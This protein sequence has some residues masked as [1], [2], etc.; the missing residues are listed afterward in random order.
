[1][2][3]KKLYKAIDTFDK[4]GKSNSIQTKDSKNAPTPSGELYSAMKSEVDRNVAKAKMQGI[5]HV[6]MRKASKQEADAM[7]SVNSKHGGVHRIEAYKSDGVVEFNKTKHD[8]KTPAGLESYRKAIT[9]GANAMDPTQA[10]KFVEFLGDKNIEGKF[11]DE[12]AQL[13][14]TLHQ[15]GKGKINANRLVISGHGMPGGTIMDDNYDGYTLKDVKNLAKIFP[16]GSKKM[17]HVAIAACFCG[18]GKA[19]FQD[20]QDAFPNLK[21]AFA[22]KQFSPKAGEGAEVHLTKWAKTTD[23]AD[24]SGVD[25]TIAKTATWNSV[26]GYKGLSDRRFDEVMQSVNDKKSAYDAYQPGGTKKAAPQGK[27][28]PALDAYYTELGQLVT[29]DD[30]QSVFSTDDQKKYNVHLNEVLKLRTTIQSSPALARN[31]H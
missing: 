1:K 2:E 31:A 14:T 10:K 22:Y 24:P 23:G 20:M 27:H 28:D 16:E 30:F 15:V 6:G 5:I 3:F 9:S 13:G 11:R 19:N 29:H 8:L 12:L 26:D 17:E 25:P 4:D 7:Q 21:S 18:S